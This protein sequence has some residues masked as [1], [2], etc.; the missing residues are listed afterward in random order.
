VSH[1]K[2]HRCHKCGHPGAWRRRIS[3]QKKYCICE[4]HKKPA[5]PPAPV[6]PPKEKVKHKK[7]R[8]SVNAT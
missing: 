8:N 3:N 5:P 6:E 4:C 2:Q 1:G 7:P